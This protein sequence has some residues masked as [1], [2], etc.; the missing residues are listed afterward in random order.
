MDGCEHAI[1]PRTHGAENRRFANTEDA[2]T[3][4]EPIVLAAVVDFLDTH[5]PEGRCTHDARLDGHVECGV[6]EWVLGNFRGE[7]FV[8]QDLIDSLELSV[9]SGL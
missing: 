6:S 2:P 7:F 4:T 5:L 1:Q 8:G 9:A 3:T